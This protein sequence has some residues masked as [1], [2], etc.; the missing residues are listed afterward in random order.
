MTSPNLTQTQRE[1]L[2]FAVREQL[3]ISQQVAL[4]ADV[5]QRRVVRTQLLDFAFAVA[6]TSAA[7]SFLVSLG[8]VRE[9]PHEMGATKYYQASAAGVLAH[10]RGGAGT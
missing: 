2:R 7:L 9:I 8:H 6:D 5:I 10:E 3:A 4:P 1:D